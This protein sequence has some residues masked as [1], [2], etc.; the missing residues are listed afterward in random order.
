MV[1]IYLPNSKLTA[2]LSNGFSIPI[3]IEE[4]SKGSIKCVEEMVKESFSF[5][6]N[7][8]AKNKN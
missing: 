5:L 8:L 3:L 2:K 1:L 7:Y 6:K 4:P